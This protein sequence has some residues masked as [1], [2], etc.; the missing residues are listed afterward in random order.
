MA[1]TTNTVKYVVDSTQAERAL[2]NIQ[3]ESQKVNET[4]GKLKGV[5]AGLAI[6]SFI[7]NAYQMAAAIND[8]AT[9][10]SI[11][12]QSVLGFRDAIAANGG[13]ASAALDGISKFS[14]AINNAAEGSKAAQDSFL[15]L[16]VTLNDLRTM[17]EQDLLNKVVVGLGKMEA[18]AQR[19]AI[20]IDLFGK[21]FKTV[22]YDGAAASLNKFTAA[23]SGAAGGISAADKAEENFSKAFLNLQTETLKALKPVSELAV[24]MTEAGSAFSE[25]VAPVLKVVGTL[26]LLWG[27]TRLIMIAWAAL[28]TTTTAVAAAFTGV[29]AGL[30]ALRAG[31]AGLGT[32]ATRFIGQLKAIWREGAI[33][34]KTI[35]ILGWRFGKFK[36]AMTL[37][38]GGLSALA[39]PFIAFGGMIAA[40]FPKDVF[41]GLVS[42]VDAL[43]NKIGN[44]FSDSP[45]IAES[46]NIR[47]EVGNLREM[48][49][50]YRKEQQKGID[51]SKRAVQDAGKAERDSLE[52]T[53]GLYRESIIE[54]NNKYQAE[55]DGISL[56]LEQRTKLEASLAAES[57][58]LKELA[59]LKQR[60][61][62][63]SKSTSP[64]DKAA[65]E[66]VAA[67]IKEL[68][69][70]YNKQKPA[71]EALTDARLKKLSADQLEL[72]K[73]KSLIDAENRLQDLRDTMATS[74]MTTIEKKYY[75]I[76]KAAK[77][78]GKA[79]IEA[80]EARLNRKL[81]ESEKGEFEKIANAKVKT[82][83]E[84]TQADYDHARSFETGWKQAYINWQETVTDQSAIARQSFTK[85]VDGMT[86]LIMNFAKTGKFEFKSFINDIVA[87]LLRSEIQQTMAKI[88]TANKVGSAGSGGMFGG[89]GSLL[90]FA[91]G[92]TI[93]TNNPVLVGERGPEI[94]TG[95]AG[96]TVIPNNQLGGATAITYNINAVDARSFQQLVAA[97]PEFI[98]AV[99]LKGQR[100][101]PGGR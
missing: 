21:K 93:P 30:T 25:F 4:F 49:N 13:E 59:T 19:T 98:Y 38:G 69:E 18:G 101:M 7:T 41:D 71:I 64:T 70:A 52:K 33:T 56:S 99:T 94:L 37:I 1:T 73:T 12:V 90:G 96:R 6:G 82:E 65:A 60:Y 100:S 16:G 72:F 54:S 88:F 91:N 61:N 63:L 46:A 81:T 32:T 74:T 43:W 36:E 76:E 47:Q 26:A 3:K 5:I 31:F 55:T 67:A 24:K 14:Q 58:Y 68:T 28:S 87:M 85:T 10:S 29:G 45:V 42:A 44:M 9:A 66:A 50:N 40:L 15:T 75:D 95:A 78:A 23:A 48:E 53:L 34:Q 77:A 80:E 89:L 51:S 84:L 83:K 39:K 2:G 62:E 86:D 20:G 27:G 8:V 97:N 79:A 35:E 17:S 22:D 92:G 57:N 11:S